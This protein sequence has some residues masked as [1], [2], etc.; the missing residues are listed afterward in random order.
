[1]LDGWHEELRIDFEKACDGE[2]SDCWLRVAR[3]FLQELNGFWTT[4]PAQQRASSQARH[5]SARRG[6]G[7]QE[8][9]LFLQ[10]FAAQRSQ[11]PRGFQ[12]NRAGSALSKHNLEKPFTR[13]LFP[14]RC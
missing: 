10:P 14:H 11:R 13:L 9:G 8:F 2:D 4:V 12:T 6:V 7:S 5:K 1:M 3:Q